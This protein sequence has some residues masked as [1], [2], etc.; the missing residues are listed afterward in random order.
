MITHH[1]LE[2][3][4]LPLSIDNHHIK[5]DMVICGKAPSNHSLFAAIAV[6]QKINQ[7]TCP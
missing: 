3:T 5:I 6:K 2:H 1:L 4:D 7:I